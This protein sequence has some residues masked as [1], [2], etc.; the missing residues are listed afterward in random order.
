MRQ[1]K[2]NKLLSFLSVMMVSL[3]FNACTLIDDKMDT[4]G[5]DNAL[6][7]EEINKQYSKSESSEAVFLLIDEESIDNGNEP[8]YFKDSEI[9]DDISE[10]G[11]RKIL[12]YFNSKS[13]K[14]KQIVLYTGQVGD[15][16]WFA[17]TYIPSSWSNAG[18]GSEGSFNYFMA[19]PGLGHDSTE[20]YLDKVPGVVPLRATGL[21]MLIGKTVYAVVYDSDISINYSPL[22]ANLKGEN[23]GVVALTV[24]DVIERKNG[25]SS[26]L[27]AVIV[28]IEDASLVAT[29]P[30]VLFSNAPIP[31]SSSEPMDIIP[32]INVPSPKL[33]T[34]W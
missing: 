24:L 26:S 28:R 34:A 16:G 2:I 3:S 5:D 29:Y 7:N 21:K 14:G 22:N 10:V 32:P 33:V 18:P 12:P 9:N 6:Y 4:L 15:E 20:D 25:S 23:L 13:N 19:G 27:P 17:P 30:L 11:L 31:S 8:N 1:I